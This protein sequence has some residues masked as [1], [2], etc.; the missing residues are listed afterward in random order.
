MT[1]RR[2]AT[3]KKATRKRKVARKKVTR[4]RKATRK[5]ATR[6]RAARMSAADARRIENAAGKAALKALAR[7]DFHPVKTIKLPPGTVG[8]IIRYRAILER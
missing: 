1:A 4:K 3:R 6:K 7:T 2:K 8:K 5:K